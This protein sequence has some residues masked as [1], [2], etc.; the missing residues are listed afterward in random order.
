[1]KQIK[2]KS[3]YRVKSNYDV[4][5][6]FIIK[7]EA[8][9]LDF[10]LVN[11]TG[12]SRNNIK[13]L[14]KNHQVV[15]NGNP[16]KQF[17]YLLVPGDS[18]DILK[19]RHFA[20]SK[21]EL[22]IIYEDDELICINKPEELLTIASDKE[23]TRT[24]YREVNAYLRLKDLRARALI[25]HRLDKQTSGVLLFAKNH[26][27]QKRLQDNWND[28]VLSRKYYA[29]VM[30]NMPK[31]EDHLE[32]YL[33]END[34]NLMYVTKDTRN[35][36]KSIL[37]YKVVKESEKYSLLDVSIDSGRKNQIRVM[38]GSIGHYVIGDDKYGE[39]DN[40]LKRLGLHAYELSLIHPA[41]KK[42][43]LFKAKTPPSFTALFSKEK[44]K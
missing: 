16:T 39:P 14:L 37:D 10:L 12:Y 36:K 21:I 41:T 23:K 1:M 42:K 31:K 13:S 40:P 15:L 27:L 28:L 4:K 5:V 34:Y 43:L 29:I 11:L 25:V 24:A 32:M 3:A 33:K 19:N 44:V 35:G 18:L 9:L 8:Q 2:Q 22:D 17:D 30:G 20:P 7:K 6:N 26:N 38:L